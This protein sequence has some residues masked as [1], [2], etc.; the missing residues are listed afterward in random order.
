M[1][2][3]IFAFLTVYSMFHPVRVVWLALTLFYDEG[4]LSSTAFTGVRGLGVSH[5]FLFD[6]ALPAF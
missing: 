4:D 6:V 3:Y 2:V 5:A 1:T